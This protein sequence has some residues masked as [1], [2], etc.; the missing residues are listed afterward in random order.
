MVW[1]V[2]NLSAS[3]C[4]FIERI[5]DF[6]CCSGFLGEILMNCVSDSYDCL[7][8]VDQLNNVIL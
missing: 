2:L 3:I 5:F 6:F 1:F 4:F 8:G 7:L